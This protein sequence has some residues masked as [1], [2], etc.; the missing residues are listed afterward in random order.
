MNRQ[1]ATDVSVRNA[2]GADD[3]HADDGA[4]GWRIVV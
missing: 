3:A 1:I 2:A 4:G